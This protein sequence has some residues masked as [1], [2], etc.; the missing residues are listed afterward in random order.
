[1]RTD[2]NIITLEK[3]KQ[4]TLEL[5]KDEDSGYPHIIKYAYFDL[6]YA[7]KQVKEFDNLAAIAN[8]I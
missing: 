2:P 7:K 1:M 8:S 6:K 4:E 3:W 5:N